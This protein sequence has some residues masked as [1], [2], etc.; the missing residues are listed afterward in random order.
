MCECVCTPLSQTDYLPQFPFTS[1][2]SLSIPSSIQTAARCVSQVQSLNSH[3]FARRNS[4][5]GPALQSRGEYPG[6]DPSYT[7]PKGDTLSL[8]YCIYGTE[9]S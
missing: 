6:A 3:L 8:R 5:P 1:P 4:I 9:Q 7:A 2:H